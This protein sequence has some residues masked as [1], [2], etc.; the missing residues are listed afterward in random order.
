MV[1]QLISSA[2][3]ERDKIGTDPRTL[4]PQMLCAEFGAKLKGK[5]PAAPV[6][7]GFN[8]VTSA[9]NSYDAAVQAAAITADFERRLDV[10]L[11]PKTPV[12]SAEVAA[13][14]DG[15]FDDVMP[16]RLARF[17][18]AKSM[19]HEAARD[20]LA[21]HFK[22]HAADMRR[23]ALSELRVALRGHRVADVAAGVVTDAMYKCVL[24]AMQAVH[25]LFA[26]PESE[27]IKANAAALRA[28]S[29]TIAAAR[30]EAECKIAKLREALAVVS[31]IERLVHNDSEADELT[32]DDNV[33]PRAGAGDEPSKPSASAGQ[34]RSRNVVA[35]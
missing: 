13:T 25:A 31:D 27:W 33:D 17:G 4:S 21:K 1:T 8:D 29:P 34:K 14:I 26:D 16:L 23:N 10:M 12:C 30:K 18:H 11:D 22:L 2:T 20:A 24:P 3:L 28:E 7:R 9:R 32:A 15:A 5:W 6:L 19:L 35:W